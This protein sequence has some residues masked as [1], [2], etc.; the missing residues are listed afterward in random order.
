M[1]GKNPTHF[2]YNDPALIFRIKYHGDYL[3]PH[4]WNAP[5]P[6]LSFLLKVSTIVTMAELPVGIPAPTLIFQQSKLLE[7]RNYAYCKLLPTN[8]F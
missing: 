6:H 8:A 3:K 1:E 5:I 7:S 4:S 2:V